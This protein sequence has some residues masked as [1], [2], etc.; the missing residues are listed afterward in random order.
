MFTTSKFSHTPTTY[1]LYNTSIDHWTGTC[2][3]DRTDVAS[4]VDKAEFV[5]RETLMT[6]WILGWNLFRALP[7]TD[8]SEQ[9]AGEWGNGSLVKVDTHGCWLLMIA[10]LTLPV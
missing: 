8:R 1:F 7:S 5:T 3:E 4:G 9:F 6:I 2:I 10:I